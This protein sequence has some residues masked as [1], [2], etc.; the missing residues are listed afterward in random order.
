MTQV[1]KQIK[2]QVKK[3]PI[4]I[5]LEEARVIIEK[6]V[7]FYP[8][9]FHSAAHP[10]CGVGGGGDVDRSNVRS[11]YMSLR[12]CQRDSIDHAR[13]FLGSKK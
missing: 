1:K 11:S 8:I 6:L 5:A 9:G 7:R 12:D 2:K 10:G 4:A 3:Q 13:R